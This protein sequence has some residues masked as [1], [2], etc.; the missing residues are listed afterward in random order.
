VRTTTATRR[1]SSR[2]TPDLI[3]AGGPEKTVRG[4][5][6]F[7]AV[8]EPWFVGLAERGS[9]VDIDFRFTERLAVR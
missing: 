2:Y 4:F 8:T 3:R 9:S 7:V 1:R 5:R 6:E